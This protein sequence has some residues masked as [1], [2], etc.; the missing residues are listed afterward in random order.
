MNKKITYWVELATYDIDTAFAMLKAKR[1]LYVGF[2]AH[3][4]I[5]KIIKAYFVKSTSEVPPFSHSLS[6]LA[7]KANL[8]DQFSDEQKDFIDFLEP[9]NIEA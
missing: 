5:E 1:Y 9:L 7:K 4:A 8:Y 6:Y 3:Q 2:M